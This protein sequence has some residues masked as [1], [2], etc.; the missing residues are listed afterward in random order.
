MKR[1]VSI[2]LILILPVVSAFRPSESSQKTDTTAK[3]KAVFIYNFTKYIEWPKEY[4]S[5]EF[6][7]GIL[8]DYEALYEQLM[9]LSK[10]VKVS[11]QAF[12]IK[13]IE[14]TESLNSPHILYIPDDS[15]DQLSEA[16]AK[17]QGKKHTSYYGK[18]RFGKERSWYQ[19]CC[20]R[21]QA[22]IR[23]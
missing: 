23:T 15:T 7:I 19:L 11:E 13:N 4:Q 20:T 1:L 17:L 6:T 9:K 5:G 10:Q 2:L 14:N 16:L 8:G 12:S 21:E 18:T 3:I 22:K